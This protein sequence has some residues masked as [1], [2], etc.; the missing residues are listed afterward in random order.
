MTG[1]AGTSSEVPGSFCRSANLVQSVTLTCLAAG[2][3]GPFPQN[4]LLMMNNPIQHKT[5]GIT[6]FCACGLQ[7]TPLLRINPDVDVIDALTHSANLQRIASQLML[8]SAMGDGGSHLAW[9]AVFLSET[10]QAIVEDLS[11]ARVR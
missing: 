1:C 5:P 6:T 11:M 7:D 4:G 2:G 3:D 10:A 8:D 9:A